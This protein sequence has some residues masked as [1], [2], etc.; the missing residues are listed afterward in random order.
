[1]MWVLDSEGVRLAVQVA[2]LQEEPEAETKH[3]SVSTF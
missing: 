1:M 2:G 3:H